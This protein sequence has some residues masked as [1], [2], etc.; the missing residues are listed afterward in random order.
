MP[1][2]G[3]GQNSQP[4]FPVTIFRKHSGFVVKGP[5]QLCCLWAALLAQFRKLLCR[6]CA[7]NLFSCLWCE[8]EP[9]NGHRFKSFMKY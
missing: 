2:I 3:R 6:D 5:V 4:S 1:K 7:F 8:V 9:A